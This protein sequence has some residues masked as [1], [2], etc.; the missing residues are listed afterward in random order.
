QGLDVTNEDDQVYVPLT[1][2]M[3][4]LVNVDY[5]N[6]IL[7][8][9]ADWSTMDVDAR[10]ADEL[11]RTRH[12]VLAGQREDFQIQNE[13]SLIDTQTASSA[14]LDALVRWIGASGLIVSG[15]GV[16]AIAWI[17]VRDRTME[18]GTRRALGATAT[19]VFLQFLFEGF[20]LAAIASVAGLLV[21]IVTSYTLAARAGLP[22]V[23][24]RGPAFA[25]LA[26]A[27]LLNLVF[28]AWPS[29]RAARMD[30]INALRHE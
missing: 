4:R 22:P 21:G 14:R 25:A 9:L 7:F 3:R 26:M 13:K 29:L 11:L 24:E 28:A 12:P 30:P 1:T 23:F 16:L 19:N 6:A 2:L 8:E 27:L 20:V 17:A 15:L 10:R 18:I 5:F